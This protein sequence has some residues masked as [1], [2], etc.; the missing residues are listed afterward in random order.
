MKTKS[1]NY[2]INKF[3]LLNIDNW[4][5]AREKENYG[6]GGKFLS[7]LEL[8][9]EFTK[10]FHEDDYARLIGEYQQIENS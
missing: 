4:A 2:N 10:L 1:T 7:D 8:R 6:N 3:L 9:K 5:L